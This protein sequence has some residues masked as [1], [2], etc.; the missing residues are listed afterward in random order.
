MN[1]LHFYD[2][3][4]SLSLILYRIGVKIVSQIKNVIYDFCR[5]THIL[6][7]ILISPPVCISL[8]VLF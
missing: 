2:L 8:L 4:S 6:I 5:Q 3:M 7:R 1:F